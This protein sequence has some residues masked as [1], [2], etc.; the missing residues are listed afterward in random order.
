MD[1]PPV[2]NNFIGL[3]NKAGYHPGLSK[4]AMNHPGN[5]KEIPQLEP[6]QK[7]YDPTWNI[8][9]GYHRVCSLSYGPSG[10]IKEIPQ[11]GPG[12]KS[13]DPTGNIKKGYHRIC[14]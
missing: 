6:G 7:S 10:N 3:G 9:K 12:Q 14:S 11:L 1:I 8:K 5:I 4:K 13:Y 2:F